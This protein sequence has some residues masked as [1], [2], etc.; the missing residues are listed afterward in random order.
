VKLGAA[1][2]VL[3]LA[4]VCA[5]SA[6]ARPAVSPG[7]YISQYLG[8]YDQLAQIVQSDKG[9]CVKMA[10]DLRGWSVK[11][12]AKIAALQAAAPKVSGTALALAAMHYESKLVADAEKIATNAITCERNAQVAAALA[13]Q[14]KLKKP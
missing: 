3:L 1:A 10:T 5:A 13:A 7:S 2:A 11:N 14:G 9:N 4:L 12:K 6:G 8:L